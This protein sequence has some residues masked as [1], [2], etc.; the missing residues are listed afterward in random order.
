M[1]KSFTVYKR[2]NS[3]KKKSRYFFHRAERSVIFM[4]STSQLYYGNRLD[5]YEHNYIQYMVEFYVQF[6]NVRII[7]CGK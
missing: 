1:Y 3:N 4:K 7:F 5:D 6:L 2:V